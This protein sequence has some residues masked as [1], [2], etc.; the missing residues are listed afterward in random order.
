VTLSVIVPALNEAAQIERCLSWLRREHDGEIL[1][2][3][4]G[5]TDDT[6][7]RARLTNVKVID[8]ERGLARQLNA[9][10]R[11]ATGEILFFVAADSR[12]QPGW[13]RKILEALESPYVV[14][15]GLRLKLDDSGWGLKVIAWGGNFRSRYLGITLPDQ[16]LFVRREAFEKAGGLSQES[17][18]PY[19]P[20]CHRLK[21]LGEFRLLSHDMVSSA[22]KWR[23]GGLIRTSARHVW[24]YL[25]F[26]SREL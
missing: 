1:V 16:G 11:A 22:R 20:L 5:S 15:G 25:R 13:R 6:V 4:G 18:I 9:A 7:A 3:D 10:A 21:A 8:S 14:G 23:E 19:V 26:K 12:P 17:M 2:V 24:I